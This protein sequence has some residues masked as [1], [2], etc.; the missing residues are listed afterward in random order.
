M[1]AAT[2][3]NGCVRAG[4]ARLPRAAAAPPLEPRVHCVSGMSDLH[5]HGIATSSVSAALGAD[6]YR[7]DARLGDALRLAAAGRLEPAR[8]SFA[9][10]SQSLTRHIA[11][12]EG[13]LFPVFEARVGVVGPTSVMRH[14]HRAIAATLQR[15]QSAL[16][17]GD[18]GAFCDEGEELSTMMAAH[19]HKEERV[20]YPR[21]DDTLDELER[22]ALVLSLGL[23]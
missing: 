10:F 19:N 7:L 3:E 8:T 15:A 22:A 1:R 5:P 21:T 18:A 13:L 6:H 17:D 9:A 11:A 12:E 2:A 4:I 14:E 16:D 20:I 23:G